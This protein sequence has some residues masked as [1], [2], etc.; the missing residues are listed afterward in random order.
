MQARSLSSGTRTKESSQRMSWVY[1]ANSTWDMSR[2]LAAKVYARDENN[3]RCAF[4]VGHL[5]RPSPDQQLQLLSKP[6]ISWQI[7]C[8]VRRL[9]VSIWA[10]T[11]F[12]LNPDRPAARVASSKSSALRTSALRANCACDRSSRKVRRRPTTTRVFFKTHVQ[13]DV[14]HFLQLR[15]MEK[16]SLRTTPTKY[17]S[18]TVIVYNA[19]LGSPSRRKIC[20]TAAKANRLLPGA[21][22]FLQRPSK[23]TPTESHAQARR[24]RHK[25]SRQ[26][27]Q[28]SQSAT[29]RHWPRSY[30]LTGPN[31][32][33]ATQKIFCWNL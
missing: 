19:L 24:K 12:I 18:G 27:L 4:A 10:S 28:D 33:K 11:F 14:D 9:A 29:S 3:S 5:Q 15:A 20:R 32:P 23:T 17:F 13:T 16:V 1:V 2:R 6:T 7:S 26:D 8:T 22:M 31:W 30:K 21:S 25:S